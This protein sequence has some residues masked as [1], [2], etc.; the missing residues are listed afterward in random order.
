MYRSHV[1][2]FPRAKVCR[3]TLVGMHRCFEVRC[4]SRKS[5]RSDGFHWTRSDV[6]SS[7]CI[8][9]VCRLFF[10]AVRESE[11]E[12]SDSVRPFPRARACRNAFVRMHRCLE[13]KSTSQESDRY[14]W[15]LSVDYVL[16]P[17]DI[18]HCG[19]RW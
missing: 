13:M 7:F 17:E 1:M 8:F 16:L 12:T 19:N 11:A 10:I 14:I 5:G 4:A 3:D 6:Q 2:S 9:T 15:W 18:V